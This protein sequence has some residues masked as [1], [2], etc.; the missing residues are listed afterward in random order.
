MLTVH[1]GTSGPA[2]AVRGELVE[3]VGPRAELTARFPTARLRDW[4]G[5]VG[6]GRTHAGPVP[7]APSPRERIH[8]LLTE[9][10]TAL[11]FAAVADDPALREAA[12]R[13]GVRLLPAGATPPALVVGARADLAV[14]TDDGRCVATVLAG[15]LV[16]RRA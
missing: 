2:V 7:D 4:P 8:A 11:P 13:A 9:G 16:H 3:A 10:A 14:H 15:R 6:A 12:T 5:A 1:C